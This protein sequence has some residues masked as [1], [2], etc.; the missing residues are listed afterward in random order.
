LAAIPVGPLPTGTA[1]VTLTSE[2]AARVAALAGD[3][4]TAA[5]GGAQKS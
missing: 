2:D 5:A 1:A 4:G 3:A